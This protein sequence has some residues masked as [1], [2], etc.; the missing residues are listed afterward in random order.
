MVVTGSTWL[1]WGQCVLFFAKTAMHGSHGTALRG[2][3]G[4]YVAV[5]GSTS[6]S[7]FFFAKITLRGSYGTALCGSDGVYMAVTW[8]T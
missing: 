6:L 4:V 2:R 8:S 7:F 3:D 1:L 5:T